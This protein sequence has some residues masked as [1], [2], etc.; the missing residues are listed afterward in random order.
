MTLATPTTSGIPLR[1]GDFQTLTDA[2]DYAA[3]GETGINFYNSKGKLEIRLSYQQLQIEAQEMGQ[4]L[5]GLAPK[6]ALIGILA[7]TSPDFVRTFFACQYAGLVPVPMPIPTTMGGKD[8]YIGQITQMCD[9]AKITALFSPARL[10]D[11][12]GE[13]PK[14]LGIQLIDMSAPDLPVS[15]GHLPS[16]RYGQLQWH[17]YARLTGAPWRSCRFLAA[18]IS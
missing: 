10:L 2:L 16:L 18:T 13:T 12:L 17:N 7:E 6:D 14:T 4:R 9:T 5:I 15:V 8:T 3:T 11:L 1:L